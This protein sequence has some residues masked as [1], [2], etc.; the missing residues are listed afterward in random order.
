MYRKIALKTQHTLI[1]NFLFCNF[2][3]KT[4]NHLFNVCQLKQTKVTMLITALSIYSPG[5][6]FLMIHYT[7][8]S[9]IE[10][11]EMILTHF[12]WCELRL[13]DQQR[14][15]ILSNF[16]YGH[17]HFYSYIKFYV[18]LFH[19]VVT[20]TKSS[21]QIVAYIAKALERARHIRNG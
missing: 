9:I 1:G 12:W 21:R 8:F 16:K 15:I 10:H 20:V 3:T 19:S 6:P 18:K 2:D 5:F 17:F 7:F 4:E 13:R 11:Q 14:S